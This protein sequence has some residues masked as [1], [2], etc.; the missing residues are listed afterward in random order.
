M[1]IGSRWKTAF[2]SPVNPKRREVR[3]AA[4]GP[5]LG[6]NNFTMFGVSLGDGRG[7]AA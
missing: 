1:T 4:P 3:L 6:P 2:P 7:P 5:L